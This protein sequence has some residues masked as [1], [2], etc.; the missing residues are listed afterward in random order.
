MAVPQP[1]ARLA[2]LLV[3]LALKDG[4]GL[5]V[6]LVHERR[7]VLELGHDGKFVSRIRR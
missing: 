3:G 6:D 7:I 4:F 5:C 2:R 1:H